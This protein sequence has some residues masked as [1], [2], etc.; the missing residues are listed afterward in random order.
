MFEKRR[1]ACQLTVAAGNLSSIHYEQEWS[2]SMRNE[3]LSTSFYLTTRYLLSIRAPTTDVTSFSLAL[4][5]ISIV[6]RNYLL[7]RSL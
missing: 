2:E 4:N 7:I 6:A 3:V 1:Q 5:R